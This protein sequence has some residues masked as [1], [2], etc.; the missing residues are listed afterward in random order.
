MKRKV[1]QHGKNT[2]TISLPTDWVKR[3]K[4]KIG[5]ELEVSDKVITLEI[6][7]EKSNEKK[8]IV[9]DIEDIN[10]HLIKRVVGNLYRKGYDSITL[11]FSDEKIKQL[12]L[13]ALSSFLEQCIGLEILSHEAKSIHAKSVASVMEGEFANVLRRYFLLS[14]QAIDVFSDALKQENFSLL[15]TVIDLEKRQNSLYLYTTRVL[16]K[17]I[18]FS[19]EEVILYYLLIER[20]EE[21]LDEYRDMALYLQEKQKIKVEKDFLRFL[22]EA[23][24]YLHLIYTLYYSFDEKKIP[25]I[26]AKRT[27]F[28]DLQRT[29]FDGKKPFEIPLYHYLC[30]AFVKM[31]ETSSPIVGLH[32]GN[33]FK[34]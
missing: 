5:D 21:L 33:E 28:A 32:L 17:T 9:L 7:K 8:E 23:K 19:K 14:L 18:S 27:Y 13:D 31:Y 3:N 1:V 30:T 12:A 22:D 24:A 16:N 26:T 4:I 10:T 2:L 20:L 34:R 15:S 11:R 6:A 29:V 25:E